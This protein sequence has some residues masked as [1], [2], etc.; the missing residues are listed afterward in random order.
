MPRQSYTHPTEIS[1]ELR[2][3]LP[4]GPVTS[5]AEDQL[6]HIEHARE[7]KS[8]ICEVVQSSGDIE[9]HV[10]EE[11]KNAI[12][13]LS[14]FG[15]GKST[16]YYLLKHEL[17]SRD[18]FEMVRLSA[19][20]HDAGDLRI[21]MLRKIHW[22]LKSKENGYNEEQLEPEQIKEISEDFDNLFYTKASTQRVEIAPAPAEARKM[23]NQ[24]VMLE[25]GVAGVLALMI[26]FLLY[27]VLQS[28]T[29]EFAIVFGIPAFA[30]IG[31]TFLLHHLIKRYSDHFSAYAKPGHITTA[32]ELPRTSK[33]L[34]A[35]FG[36]FVR[37]WHVNSKSRMPVFFI[38]DIDRQRS[39][40]VVEVLDA[41]RTFMEMGDCVFIVA[42]DESR[43]KEAVAF[44]RGEKD[45]LL[46]SK[47]GPTA[48][49]DYIQRYCPHA[50]RLPPFEAKDM[51]GFAVRAIR[52]PS[53]KHVLTYLAE[54]Q[55]FP[56]RE[57]VEILIHGKK[58]G[59]V[60]F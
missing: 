24:A 59:Q 53:N 43:L 35:I 42:C 2:S 57:V 7:L 38:D 33:Q 6:N 23:A 10:G 47:H 32:R 60:L 9:G 49:D 17:A 36:H 56:L 46:E 54:K 51:V 18:E 3:R 19:W 44:S 26:G 52:H 1:S 40:R 37:E 15:T 22:S 50:H 39:S 41:V 27:V 12:A 5:P 48:Y 25:F 55:A 8:L 20:K 4:A 28:V 13:L 11:R 58:R 45:K 34:E 29:N 31:G 30:V 14:D 21:A 16:I